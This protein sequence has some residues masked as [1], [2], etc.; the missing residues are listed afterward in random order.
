MNPAWKDVRVR[1]LKFLTTGV[2]AGALI[3]ACFCPHRLIF[4]SISVACGPL[5]F[6]CRVT[7]MSPRVDALAE[8]SQVFL[9]IRSTPRARQLQPPPPQPATSVFLR[10]VHSHW[11][12]GPDASLSLGHVRLLHKQNKTYAAARASSVLFLGRPTFEL[13]RTRLTPARPCVTRPG[14]GLPAVY[15]R[16]GSSRDRMACPPW[17]TG[18]RLVHLDLKGAPP[19]MEYLLKVTPPYLVIET[20]PTLMTSP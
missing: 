15:R 5:L 12:W 4:R 19:R 16:G 8:A 3:Y 13:Q 9:W 2:T 18:R 7:A 14:E 1:V 17:P 11:L 6:L 20:P 10:V